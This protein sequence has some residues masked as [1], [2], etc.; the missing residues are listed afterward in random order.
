MTL[1]VNYKQDNYKSLTSTVK[2]CQSIAEDFDFE[3]NV[4]INLDNANK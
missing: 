4:A 3:G 2:M 1:F